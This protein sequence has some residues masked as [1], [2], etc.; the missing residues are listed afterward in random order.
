ML[1][2]ADMPKQEALVV[3]IQPVK[4]PEPHDRAERLPHSLVP[5]S[6][7]VQLQAFVHNLLAVAA[8]RRCERSRRLPSALPSDCLRM[9]LDVPENTTPGGFPLLKAPPH[10]ATPCA[11][12]YDRSESAQSALE[13]R[14][15]RARAI[16]GRRAS[17]RKSQAEQLRH[18]P[19]ARNR[20]HVTR[21]CLCMCDGEDEFACVVA[22][23]I[24][25]FPGL[26]TVVVVCPSPLH[27][28]S[29]DPATS[30]SI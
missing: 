8:P 5:A 1:V 9:L 29:A 21:M 14:D 18:R 7:R 26:E 16:H 13:R 6:R 2:M 23:L 15:G 10:S 22:R 17:L 24:F 30:A 4:H 12:C 3:M 20:C 19:A 25:S 27:G 28:V 11:R